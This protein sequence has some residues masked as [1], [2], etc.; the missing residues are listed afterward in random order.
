MRDYGAADAT[1]TRELDLH[2][3]PEIEPGG[4]GTGYVGDCLHS[5]RLALREATFERVVPRAISLGNDTD[6]TAAVAAG[7]AGV[8]HGFSAIPTRWIAAL[9]GRSLV[10]PLADRLV[11]SLREGRSR[12]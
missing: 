8:R 12:T 7:I 3:R 2:V 6:T 9:A 10:D 11:A 1:W 5:A 4:R